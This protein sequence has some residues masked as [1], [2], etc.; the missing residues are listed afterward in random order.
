M[1]SLIQR[2]SPVEVDILQKTLIPL[3]TPRLNIKHKNTHE[4]QWKHERHFYT[5]FRLQELFKYTNKKV[6]RDCKICTARGV[7][8]PMACRVWGHQEPESGGKKQI[9]VHLCRFF[10]A[11]HH[12]IIPLPGK[13]LGTR[14]WGTPRKEPGTSDWGIP[15]PLLTERHL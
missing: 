11:S 15:A 12:D 8:C 3:V 6:Q 13:A 4:W 9:F 14:D 2:E 10:I 7:S 1:K 5:G